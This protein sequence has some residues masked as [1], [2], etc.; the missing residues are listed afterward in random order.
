MVGLTG[1]CQRTKSNG[2]CV[3]CGPGREHG[4]KIDGSIVQIHQSDV[5]NG[6]Q[7]LN[8]PVGSIGEHQRYPVV[9]CGE[10]YLRLLRVQFPGKQS[11]DASDALGNGQLRTGRVLNGAMPERSPMVSR[12]NGENATIV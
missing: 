2:T 11:V 3:Q 12:P 1:R 8:G 7:N 9:K 10:G 5:A 6:D 4:R